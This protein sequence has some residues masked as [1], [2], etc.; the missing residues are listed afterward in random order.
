MKKRGIIKLITGPVRSGKSTELEKRLNKYEIAKKEVLR[1]RAKIDTVEKTHGGAEKKG[2]KV[3]NL[4]DAKKF[5]DFEDFDVI[6]IDEG[7]FFEDLVEFCDECANRGKIVIVAALDAN[8]DRKPFGKTCELF[9]VS[10]DPIKLKAVC[11]FCR[12]E[13]AI[14]SFKT[15]TSTSEVD[16]G[17]HYVPCCR[18]CYHE[19]SYRTQKCK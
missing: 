15:T 18:E 8:S 12:K 4:Y 14:F 11:E 1:L 2:I 6:G 10:E 7:Q 5:K 3:L 17:T 16:V 13:N 19:I 9:A